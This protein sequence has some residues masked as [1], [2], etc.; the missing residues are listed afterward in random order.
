[1]RSD[2]DSRSGAP[3]AVDV[4]RRLRA[5]NRK[6]AWT[7]SS[8]AVVFF[9]GIIATRWV[10][11][12]TIGI[13]VMGTA[14]LLFLLIAIGRNLRRTDEPQGDAPALKD[15]SARERADAN[16]QPRDAS[17]ASSEVRQ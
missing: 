6:V 9:G 5:S 15:T 17:G 13:G 1:M 12:G 10:G 3:P 11:G 7:L 16:P 4:A 14:V 8:I 2:M